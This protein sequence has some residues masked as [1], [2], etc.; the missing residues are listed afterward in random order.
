MKH[1]NIPLFCCCHFKP[2]RS[3]LWWDLFHFYV[4]H[5]EPTYHPIFVKRFGCEGLVHP[6]RS[7]FL[8]GL[9]SVM[10]KF[11]RDSQAISEVKLGFLDAGHLPFSVTET[12]FPTVGEKSENLEWEWENVIEEQSKSQDDLD[13]V[14]VS[15][16]T[17]IWPGK[18]RGYWFVLDKAWNRWNVHPGP[19]FRVGFLFLLVGIKLTIIYLPIRFYQGELLNIRPGRSAAWVFPDQAIPPSALSRTQGKCT[20]A[21]QVIVQV[22]ASH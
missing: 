13:K 17:M 14:C 6:R 12:Y 21:K 20:M 3:F 16:C 11:K 4:L 5:I 8:Y 22:K 1:F 19:V 10:N 9:Y 7:S 15:G 18:R 2:W